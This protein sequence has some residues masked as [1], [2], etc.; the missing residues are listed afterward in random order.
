MVIAID[1]PAG[2]GKSSTAK[3]VAKK[4]NFL[5]LDTGAMYRAVTLKCLRE[6]ISYRD[7][8]ALSQVVRKSSILFSGRVPDTRVFLDSEDVT[9]EIRSER[10]T[11]SVSDYCAPAVVRN[12]LVANQRMIAKGRS[13][14]SEGRDMGTVVFPD[15]EIKVYMTASVEER[16]RRRHNQLLEA[17]IQKN[18]SNL[19]SEIRERDRKDSTRKNSPLK[20]ADDA[21]ELD[22][23]AMSL[24]E[25][26]ERIS[27]MAAERTSKESV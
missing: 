22:T 20:K 26:I 19:I 2:S 27:E 23:T 1:G 14:V 25:Q 8:E 12:E 9:E 3:G 11:N 21:V 17:G 18:M 15:A 7:E 10:V 5:H 13:V 16:A 6:G 4:L 24:E